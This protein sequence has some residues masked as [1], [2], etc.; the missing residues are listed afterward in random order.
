MSM[1]IFVVPTISF[2]PFVRIS[3]T[4]AFA[5]GRCVVRCD[6]ASPSRP[7]GILDG[8]KESHL[9]KAS[10]RARVAA[11]FS[12]LPLVSG[13]GLICMRSASKSPSSSVSFCRSCW[14]AFSC[15]GRCAATILT[16]RSKAFPTSSRTAWSISRS[17][18]S[19]YSRAFHACGSA[20]GIGCRSRS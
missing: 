11:A 20:R 15:T 16:A 19:L 6:R 2:R 9:R 13:S 5:A 10:G 14:A 4:A 18:S 7:F 17:V 12:A 3:C 1:D 8:R